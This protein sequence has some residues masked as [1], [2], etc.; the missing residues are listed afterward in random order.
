KEEVIE[1]ILASEANLK[2]KAQGLIDAALQFGSTD[3][4]T[5]ALI[6]V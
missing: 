1:K 4:V 5:V 3:N 2:D 6:R